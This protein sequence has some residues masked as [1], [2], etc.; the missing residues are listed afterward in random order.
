MPLIDLTDADFDE[1]IRG[2]DVPILVDFWAAWCGPCRIL[3]PTLERLATTFAGRAK[4]ARVNVDSNRIT[5]EAYGIRSIPTLIL[6]RGGRP[7]TKSV[8]V[9]TLAQLTSLLDKALVPEVQKV[10]H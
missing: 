5:S 3:E 7:V 4:V 9:A 10:T 2:D 1:A 6:F 8:G